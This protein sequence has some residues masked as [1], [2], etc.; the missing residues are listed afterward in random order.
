MYR[1][2]FLTSRRP[3][4]TRVFDLQTY[5]RNIS[6]D[7][8]TLPQHFKDNG[9]VTQSVGKVFH[10]GI[11]S[12]NTDDY[13]YSWTFP[14]YHPATEKHMFGLASEDGKLHKNAVC[15]VSNMSLVPGQS[16][17][18]IGI[19]DFAVQFLQ[20]RAKDPDQP[21]FLAVGFHKPHQPL[22]YPKEY[23]DLYPLSKI[24]PA[25]DNFFP[26]WLPPVAWAPC[27]PL[28]LN[29][30]VQAAGFPMPYGPLPEDFQ[31][32]LRQSY[33]AATSY[34]DAQLGRVLEALD[35]AGFANN[36]I[37]SFHG[38]HGWSLGE[39]EEWCKFTNFD[40][41]TRIPLMFYVPG[42]TSVPAPPPGQTF[43]FYDALSMAHDDQQDAGKDSSLSDH[44]CKGGSFDKCRVNDD[45]PDS[46]GR[47]TDALAE[48]VDIY[49][50]LCELAGLEMPPMC[51]P[52]DVKVKFCTTG[53]SL[54]P[55]IRNVTH[56][57][58]VTQWKRAAF[59]QYTRP[60]YFPQIISDGPVLELIRI[61]GYTMRTADH[62]YTEWVA[63]DPATFTTNWTQLYA[64]ELYVYET[65][66]LEDWNV[67]DV[68]SHSDLVVELSKQ[69]RAGWREALPGQQ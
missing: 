6:G 22:R 4:T 7:F 67:A 8:T 37:I 13:P 66:P 63:Y 28:R 5:F 64:R 35:K 24:K 48:A 40:V 43:P 41:T 9:Y 53:V 10:P 51:P 3:D 17:P 26:M 47:T 61:M 62:R 49:P 31:L 69:L 1:T 58:P 65:D 55:V 21:F 57:S 14:A 20:D 32:K 23:L 45:T 27:Y 2:S 19:A 12:N 38:D 46:Q 36:T 42:M 11:A 52:D 39:H 30:D 33:S 15:P 68:T 60:S 25:V 44:S 59:S 16:L 29:E 18:D 50:T 34:T 56:S 54:V